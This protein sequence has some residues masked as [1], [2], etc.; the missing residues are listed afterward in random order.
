METVLNYHLG[1]GGGGHLSTPVKHKRAYY[2]LQLAAPQNEAL[3]RS[4]PGR[5]MLADSYY[6][7]SLYSTTVSP[8]P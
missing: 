5:Y 2:S 4:W 3:Y 7:H 6:Q 8:V 1:G